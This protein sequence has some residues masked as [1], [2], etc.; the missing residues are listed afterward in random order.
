VTVP[1][2][3]LA[4]LARLTDE[5]GIFEHAMGAIPRRAHG[6][7]ADDQGRALALV[8]RAPDD[9]RAPRLAETYL[10]FLLHAHRGAGMFH[11]RM[12]YDRSWN[13]DAHSDD[14]DAR[15]I[16]GLAIAAT[17][18]PEHLRWSAGKILE[19]ALA[20]RSRHPRAM[21]QAAVGA[22][23]LVAA[24]RDRPSATAL[25]EAARSSLPRP[26]REGPWPWP[27]PR[28]TY[29][30]ALLPE[31][32]IAVG[33]ALGDE[34]S[35]QDGLALLRWLVLSETVEDRFSFTP[36]GGRGP[37]DRR[38][39]FDQQPIE[40]ASMAE[41]CARAFEATGDPLWLEPLE[42]AAAWCLGRNDAGVPLLDPS[43]WGGFDG[44]TTRGVNRNEGAES[45]VSVIAALRSAQRH[46]PGA[47]WDR[48]VTVPQREE[49]SLAS[50]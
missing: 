30:N 10:A 28:L 6:W 23:E 7:C 24:D 35:L 48:L 33:V 43:T 19:D 22:A 29:A 37:G 1:N 41:S 13:A 40:A 34:E 15:A 31:G 8:S 3:S 14:A 27:A 38:P 32:L 44:L 50:R 18:G 47:A 20:F 9:P 16:F 36:V 42:R 5:T 21:A 46:L 39:A 12:G 17:R 45:T 11:L 49:A 2:P 25:L 26:A 4:H